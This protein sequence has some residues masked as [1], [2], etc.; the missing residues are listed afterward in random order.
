MNTIRLMI[1]ALM[2]AGAT[3][4]KEAANKLSGPDTDAQ[5]KALIK[6]ATK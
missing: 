6:Q 5:A 2:A 3:I 1:T 4:S